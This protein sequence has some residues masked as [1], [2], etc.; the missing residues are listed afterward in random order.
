MSAKAKPARKHQD[1]DVFARVFRVFADTPWL[2]YGLWLPDERPTMPT[3][4]Q[5]QER[6]VDKLLA[7]LPP[8]PARILDI[9]GGTGAMSER[10]A[11]MGYSVEMLTPSE[12]QVQMARETLGDRVTVH[13]T[14]LQDF[15]SESR[16]DVCLFSESFQ[17]VPLDESLPKVAGLLA[18]GG[19]VV[20]SDCFRS[21]GFPGGRAVGGGHRFTDFEAAVERHNY[22][23][24]TDED[25]TTMAAPTIA[26]DRQI[27][28]EVLS[29]L[30]ADG[31]SML[32][33]RKPWAHWLVGRAWKWFVSPRERQRIA[34]RLEAE[35]RTPEKFLE[36]NTYRFITL[37]PR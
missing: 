19:R 6:Y 13:L 8:A 31:G 3:V 5:A 2:H 10:L 37:K 18:D 28:R 17:Y 36:N 11:G 27:Y 4:R 30:I 12:V 26:L 35:Y 24:V 25:V 15:T 1:L 16:F 21:A 20:I 9:G 32:K 29:P 7:L 33:E 14:R 22:Q 34:E 23:I